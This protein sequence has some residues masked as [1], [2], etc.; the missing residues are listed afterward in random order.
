MR[1]KN[2]GGAGSEVGGNDGVLHTGTSNAGTEVGQGFLGGRWVEGVRVM[3][4]SD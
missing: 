4:G 3:A 2:G 1:I